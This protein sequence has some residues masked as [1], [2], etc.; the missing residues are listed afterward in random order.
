MLTFQR[1]LFV[2]AFTF[3]SVHAIRLTYRVWLEPRTS[4]LDAYD[5]AVEVEIRQAESLDELVRQ[6]E[7][8]RQRVEAYEADEANPSPEAH[9]RGNKEPYKTEGRL[10][11]AIQDW[12]RKSAEIRKIRVYWFSGLLFL[13]LGM[14]LHRWVNG[15]V[16]I[17]ALIVAFS[18]MIYWSSP[19]YFSGFSREFERLLQNKFALAWTSFALLLLAGILSGTIGRDR[20]AP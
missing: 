7:A 3:L 15:W 14:A 6:Y 1:V 18:E 20:R 17:A 2:I 16:G 13:I 4:V 19:S 10:R 12:E 11:A 8:A 5:E 9:E